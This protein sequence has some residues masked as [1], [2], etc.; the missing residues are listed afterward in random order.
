MLCVQRWIGVG[1]SVSLVGISPLAVGSQEHPS[2]RDRPTPAER[3]AAGEWPYY[4][5]DKAFTR[6]S[7]LDQINR[8]NVG[9]LRIVW[10]RPAV[11]R[12]LRDAFSDLQPSDN[13]RST[14]IMVDGL[15][16]APNAV[17]L[18]EAFDPGT[19]KTVW[20]QDPVD[21]TLQGMTGQSTRGLDSWRS[22]SDL[23]VFTVR[24]E[25]LYALDAKTGKYSLDFGD[26]GRV[27]LKRQEPWEGRFSWSAGPI[28][29]GDVVV[30]AGNHR[31]AGDFGLTKEAAPEDVR[32]FEARSGK[33]LWTF[34]VRPRPGEFAFE[35][36][37]DAWWYSGA[38]GAW[39]C[40]SADEELGYV[41]VP[42]SAP[43]NSL[44]GGHRPGANLYS[45][46]LVALSAK[47]GK[48]IWH[49]QMVHHDLW[50]YDN[51]GPPVL[52][53]ITVGGK[54]IRAV[55]QANKTGFLYVFDRVTGQPVWPI[56]ERP[57]PASTVPGE[58]ASPTQ[59]FPTKPPPFDRQGLTE[60]DLIDFTPELRAEALRVIKPFVA[61][62]LFTPP[63]IAHDGP[64]GTKG[65]I[66]IPGTWGA[67]N[68]HTGAFDPETGVYF[69]VSHTLPY[70]ND[71]V[72]PSDPKATMPYVVKQPPTPSPSQ[73][74]SAP[75]AVQWNRQRHQELISPFGLPLT[76]PP[77][78]R[79]TAIDM[80]R[81]EHAWMIANGD[82]PRNHPLLKHL[83]L[84]PLGIANRAAPV[85]TKTLLFIGEG[86]DAMPGVA[87]GAWGKK[88]RAYDKTNG[89]AVWETE[90][91]AGTTSAPMTYLFEGKQY[92]V[93]PIGGRDYPAEWVALGLP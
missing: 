70:I 69:A 64:E 81:G 61:G 15:L 12:L 54:R 6:Y 30:I 35:T 11:D 63:S 27:H 90:L 10:R 87:R 18:V 73:G 68:W 38:I 24:D 45:D 36:W 19:G 41:Y 89:K 56:E 88:F 82:G 74:S 1:L 75:A 67:A 39:C 59:P 28:V 84:P 40:L 37:G 5:G 83:N 7:P 2:K 85:V 72:K 33:L 43:S 32:G 46:S 57:V 44:Y 49:F 23:R 53:D 9:T 71:L 93:V 65:T 26:K 50:D 51:V 76:K 91:P 78:G 17:G 92:I 79:I 60:D 8:G 13:L 29:V 55:M 62:P 80:H 31:E 25:Y 21:K 66:V 4:G 47:T 42:L 22:G 20:V 86:S 58:Q 48:R 77:Y 3:P 16:Y 14:P 34:N 52:G